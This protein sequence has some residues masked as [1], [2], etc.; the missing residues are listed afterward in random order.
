[1]SEPLAPPD[2]HSA[3]P[4]ILRQAVAQAGAEEPAGPTFTDYFFDLGRWIASLVESVLE[5][6][7]DT[8]SLELYVAYATVFVALAALA[9]LVIVALRHRRRRREGRGVPETEELA[10]AAPAALAARDAEWWW[11]EAGRRLAAGALRPALAALWWWTARRL[12]PPALDATWTTGELLRTSGPVALGLRPPMRRL[13]ALLWG[14]A[15]PLPEQVEEL[16]GELRRRLE[17]ASAGPGD[18]GPSGPAGGGG[19]S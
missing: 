15:P 18:G 11:S 16:R 6:G 7:A 12:D 4:A 17:A 8:T 10:L 14:A 1:V 2:W 19:R 9:I 5:V 3:D 13:D